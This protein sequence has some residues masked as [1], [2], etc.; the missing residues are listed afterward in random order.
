[1]KKKKL[2]EVKTQTV[3]RNRRNFLKVSGLALA[4]SSLL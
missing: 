4:G 2:I 3:G 1:M